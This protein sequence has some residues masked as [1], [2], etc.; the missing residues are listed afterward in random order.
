MK[1][2][3]F[4]VCLILTCGAATAELSVPEF[5][6][7]TVSIEVE[8]S[9]F[10]QY[11]VVN[12]ETP[13]NSVEEVS[14]NASGNTHV[15]SRSVADSS[16]DNRISADDIEVY[17]TDDTD[18]LTLSSVLENGSA[19][20]SGRFDQNDSVNYTAGRTV[21]A[22]EQS[23][24][25][26]TETVKIGEPGSFRSLKAESGDNLGFSYFDGSERVTNTTV[27]DVE[28]PEFTGAAQVSGRE[29]V[30]EFSEA[31]SGPSENIGK[32]SVAFPNLD[33]AVPTDVSVSRGGSSFTAEVR[34]NTSISTGRQ[35]LTEFTSN[36]TD[37]AGN[38]AT[39]AAVTASDRAPPRPTAIYSR[40]TDADGRLDTVE[41]TTSEQLES[42]ASLDQVFSVSQ[43]GDSLQTDRNQ[44]NGNQVT[45]ELS[46]S[47]IWTGKVGVQYSPGGLSPLSDREGNEMD[48]FTRDSL[49]R[50]QPI[51][52]GAV[53]NKSS[54][55]DSETVINLV[56]S[57]QVR[58]VAGTDPTVAVDGDAQ[59]VRVSEGQVNTTVSGSLDM[60]S[61]HTVSGVTGVNDGRG[62]SVRSSSV[63]VRV[64]PNSSRTGERVEAVILSEGWN[65][66]S[67][68]IDTGS[69]VPVDD[70]FS[71]TSSVESIWGYA[72]GEWSAGIPGSEATEVS[73]MRGGLGYAIELRSPV[74]FAPKLPAAEDAPSDVS[75]GQQWV[76]AGGTEPYRQQ[77]SE[78][79]AFSHLDGVGDVRKLD[80]GEIDQSRSVSGEAKP[81]DGYWVEVDG[82]TLT[83]SFGE[84]SSLEDLLGWLWR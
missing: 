55:G 31:I 49:D 27:L 20:V 42:S 54:S 11:V 36:L 52:V 61:A 30:L 19:E 13:Q 25:S 81:G 38:T 14:E 6:N 3:V 35:P 39:G 68:P 15:T 23:P 12:A 60:T 58:S 5:S 79:G 71:N 33:S 66:I 57:E 16:G 10:S 9:D 70:V 18:T 76:L 73:H 69:R 51:L 45:L 77:A 22:T 67:L 1:R 37:A 17:S 28:A 59:P 78:T 26:F 62:N 48:A 82:G 29:V 32:D 2:L 63:R 41:I 50:A 56:F 34:L 74:E 53:V 80:N 7:R 84:S 47:K 72:D 8:D 21:N 83:G 75:A 43:D 24:G 4:A 65:L 40:D 44:L 64:F 46:E